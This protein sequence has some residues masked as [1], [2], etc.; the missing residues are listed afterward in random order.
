MRQGI[1]IKRVT[2][3]ALLTVLAALLLAQGALSA[4]PGWTLVKSKSASGQFAA[5]GVSATIKRPKGIAV[6]FRGKGLVVWGCSKGVSVS[7]WS[8][9]YSKSGF[10]TLANVRG[11]DSCNVVASV[12][13]SGRVVVQIY[14]KR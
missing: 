12:G 4:V 9:N 10:Y 8:K 1:T 14:K 3:A 7:T 5:T 6:R 13:D 11:K 2:L